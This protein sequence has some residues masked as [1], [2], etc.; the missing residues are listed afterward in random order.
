MHISVSVTDLDMAW[1]VINHVR[2]GFSF[3]AAF[4]QG[5]DG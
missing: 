1:Y 3:S 5:F 2:H 4:I